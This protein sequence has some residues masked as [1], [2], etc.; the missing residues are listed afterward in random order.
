AMQALEGIFR[1]YE[2]ES[3]PMK[4]AALEKMKDAAGNATALKTVAELAIAAAD[5]ATA[6]D[7]YA[8]AAK[9]GQVALSA[10]KKGN[11]PG[12]VTDEA[13]AQLVRSQK[14]ADAFA[15]VKAAL[16]RLKTDPE[17]AA[18]ANTVGR[19]RCFVQARW[20]DGMKLLAKGAT[21]AVKTAAEL[22]VA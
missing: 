13:E 19:Y 18:A 7:E 8:V 11:L 9:F 10:A 2:V 1:F 22:D 15:P 5:T 20:D 16:E 14:A 17:D 21:G 4:L 6:N 3:S 12:A